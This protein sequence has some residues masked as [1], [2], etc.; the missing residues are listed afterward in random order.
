MVCSSKRS[1]KSLWKLKAEVLMNIMCEEHFCQERSE[2]SVRI[3]K[4]KKE[5]GSQLQGPNATE[6]KK[7]KAG[8]LNER[9]IIK[10]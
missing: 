7:K 4:V 6:P 5:L 3:I 8:Y 1:V 9:E 2:V 10:H